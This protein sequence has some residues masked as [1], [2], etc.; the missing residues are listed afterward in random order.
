MRIV[1]ADCD[2]SPHVLSAEPVTAGTCETGRKG[3]LKM[4]ADEYESAFLF[5]DKEGNHSANEIVGDDGGLG[6]TAVWT[7][8]SPLTDAVCNLVNEFVRDGWA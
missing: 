1:V 8:R 6:I 3:A 5:K 4:S 7:F 2:N